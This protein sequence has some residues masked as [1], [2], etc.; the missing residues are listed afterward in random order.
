MSDPVGSECAD[1]AEIRAE[2]VETMRLLLKDRLF[3]AAD[4]S[5]MTINVVNEDGKT[6][7]IVSAAASLVAIAGSGL[8]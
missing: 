3:Q 6:V 7:M 1:A 2:A 4:V 8:P 5:A